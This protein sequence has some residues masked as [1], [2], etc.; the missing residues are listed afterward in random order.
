MLV[1]FNSQCNGFNHEFRSSYVRYNT[2]TVNIFCFYQGDHSNLTNRIPSSRYNRIRQKIKE[3]YVSTFHAY[4]LLKTLGGASFYY[5]SMICSF[6]KFFFSRLIGQPHNQLSAVL[7][8]LAHCVNIDLRNTKSMTHSLVRYIV[9]INFLSS[10]FPHYHTQITLIFYLTNCC[11][12]ITLL[13][14]PLKFIFFCWAYYLSNFKSFVS[15][16]FKH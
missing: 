12:R 6:K 3:K 16:I 13:I 9:L 15:Y 1:Y 14:K 5:Y 2:V 4:F 7:P 8:T 10:C 11:N